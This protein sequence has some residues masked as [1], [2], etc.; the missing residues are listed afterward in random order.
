MF[1]K[2]LVAVDNSVH[3]KKV[4]E[5]GADLA[6]K[7]GAELILLN[8][9][10]IPERFN[11]HE[12]SHYV[13]LRKIEENMIKHGNDLLAT[14][15]AELEAKNLKVNTIFEKGPAGPVIV[16]KSRDEACD[17]VLVGTRGLGNVT[18]LIIGSVSN[19]V[20]HHAECPVLLVK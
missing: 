20:I 8:T 2:I 5:T 10:Y 19:Y 7:Y 14:I 18:S 3:S 15:K 4:V 11:A 17:L 1:K 12:S 9:Y 16:S 13:Y 6:A